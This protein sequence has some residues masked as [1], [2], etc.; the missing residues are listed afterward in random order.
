MSKG[1]LSTQMKEILTLY[2]EEVA[3]TT[4]KEVRTITQETVREL[5]AVSPQKEGDYAKSWTS[6]KEKNYDRMYARRETVFNEK[7]YRLT[8]LLERGHAT[9]NGGRTGAK[10]HIK[11]VEEKVKKELPER[12]IRKIKG[13]I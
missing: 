5:K 9:R 11:P 3:K 10:P 2:G 7:H 12:I 8:H 1:D 13:G 4:Q 6:Q